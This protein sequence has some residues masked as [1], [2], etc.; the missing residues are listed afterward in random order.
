MQICKPQAL[1]SD[2]CLG[3]SSLLRCPAAEL[4]IVP[5]S[6]ELASK[7][8][9]GDLAAYVLHNLTNLDYAPYST[10]GANINP[11]LGVRDAKM[12]I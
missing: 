11:G 1:I 8:K 5:D 12:V 9:V 6:P 10:A 4:F 3:V 2:Q 7:T